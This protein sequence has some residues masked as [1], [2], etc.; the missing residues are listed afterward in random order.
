MLKK[1]SK[2]TYTKIAVINNRISHG[3]YL[4]LYLL[5][6]MM[7]VFSL[8]SLLISLAFHGIHLESCN[9]PASDVIIE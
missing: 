7:T 8:I 3:V 9:A 4:F 2:D 6:R 5:F 1:F